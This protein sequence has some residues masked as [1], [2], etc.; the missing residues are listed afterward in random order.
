MRLEH[1]F[2]AHTKINSKWLKPKYKTWYHKIPRREYRHKILEHK[3]ILAIF[4]W[5]VS[6]G[7]KS[8]NKWNYNKFKSFCTSTKRLTYGMAE[9]FANIA[10]KNIQIAHIARYQEK[11]PMKK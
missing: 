4:T 10:T 11:S 3:Y 1:S 2:P 8:K 5:S 6:Q 9:I 7:K